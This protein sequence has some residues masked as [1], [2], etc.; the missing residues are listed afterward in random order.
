VLLRAA[1]HSPGSQWV[2]VRLASGREFLLVGDLVY[3]A[4]GLE[5]QS[6]RPRGTSEALKE[7]RDVLQRQLQVARALADSAGFV[8]VPAHDDALLSSLARSGA[9]RDHADLSRRP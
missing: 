9:L 2:Y 5:R 8:I 6:Q 4:A 1:G 7:D 3:N